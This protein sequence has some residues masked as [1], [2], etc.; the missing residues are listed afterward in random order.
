[1]LGALFCIL[2]APPRADSTGVIT[3]FCELPQWQSACRVK[4]GRGDNSNHP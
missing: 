2:M 3:H 1:M 4:W